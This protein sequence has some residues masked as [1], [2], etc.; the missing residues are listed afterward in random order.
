[1][2]AIVITFQDSESDLA[3]GIE[4]VRDEVV[5]AAAATQGCRACGWSTARRV[6]G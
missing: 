1:M 5:P 3:D 6:S 2:H 4:H